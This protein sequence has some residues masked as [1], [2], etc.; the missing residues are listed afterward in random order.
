MPAWPCWLLP[1]WILGLRISIV[2][3]LLQLQNIQGRDFGDFKEDLVRILG[4]QSLQ[5]IARTQNQQDVQL[6]D[7][8][9]KIRGLVATAILQGRSLE[10]ATWT[11]TFTTGSRPF[12]SLYYPKSKLPI[13]GIGREDSQTFQKCIQCRHWPTIIEYFL[14]D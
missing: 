5:L 10:E 3:N 12:L 2:Q 11:V 1:E 4:M 7:Q 8:G 13:H 9:V 14:E 6:V